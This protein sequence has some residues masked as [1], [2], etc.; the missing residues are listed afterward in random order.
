MMIKNDIAGIIARNIAEVALITDKLPGVVVIPDLR[1]WSV[2][3]MS[4]RGLNHL[5]TLY[6]PFPQI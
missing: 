1:D 3:W 2:A 4:A 5:S 6:S